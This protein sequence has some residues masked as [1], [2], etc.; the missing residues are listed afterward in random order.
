M[1]TPKAGYYTAAGKRV[2]GVTTILGRFKPADGLIWWAWN[3]GREGRDYRETRDAAADAG[4]EI[5]ALA[6]RFVH[7]PT[8]A[9]EPELATL[10]EPVRRGFEAFERWWRGCRF[11]RVA[12]AEIPLV[13]ER[14]EFGG[15]LDL[16]VY[17]EKR[18]LHLVDYKAA[19]D[20]YP[21]ALCQV[22]AYE[23]LWL[24]HHPDQPVNGERH[25]IR[26]SKEF[27][28]FVHRSYTELELGWQQFLLF[29]AAYANDA[30]LKRRAK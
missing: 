29:R 24:E 2:P 13:S 6:H 5:H 19:N 8:A 14:Y 20:V 15:T 12:G 10:S 25:I 22:A 11:V 16:L 4:T 1:P 3:E 26:F 21:E 9:F 27:G 23:N 28:D 7:D 18:R 17:D 30:V